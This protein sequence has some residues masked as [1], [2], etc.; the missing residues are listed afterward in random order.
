MIGLVVV[1]LVA[2]GVIGYEKSK[3]KPAP[4][5]P[6][7][8]VP[9]PATA[10]GSVGASDSGGVTTTAPPPA[11][12]PAPSQ[13]PATGPGVYPAGTPGAFPVLVQL[14]GGDGDGYVTAAP[15]GTVGPR[16]G[17]SKTF[18][19]G[20]GTSIVFS[21]RVVGFAPFV[22]FDHFEGPGVSTRS[23][24]FVVPA[25]TNAGFVRAVFNFLGVADG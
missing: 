15:G 7:S 24:P 19:Y 12:K 14:V 2:A 16:P 18:W 25:I 13:A 17:D 21:A 20:P 4:S 9:P 6:P 8:S 3:P 23:N 5:S 22:G 11:P 1:A 10:A